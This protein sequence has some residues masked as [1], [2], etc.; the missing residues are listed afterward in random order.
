[1]DKEVLAILRK[2]ESALESRLSSFFR[3]NRF[4]HKKSSATDGGNQVEVEYCSNELELKL[5]RSRR[6]GEINCLIR[7]STGNGSNAQEKEW[8][9]VNAL[10]VDQNDF[11]V[12][13][14]MKRVP[15]TTPSDDAQ[16]SDIAKL[17]ED[18]FHTLLIKIAQS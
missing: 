14:L 12:N 9:F 18:N 11:S 2:F 5:Y 8:I 13:E 17:L 4:R 7:S 16:I 6:E 15:E 10:L 3:K 1:M